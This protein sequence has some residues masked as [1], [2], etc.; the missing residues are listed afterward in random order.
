MSLE[1][2]ELIINSD[3]SIYHLHLLPEDI[4]DTILLVGDPNRVPMVSK[5]FD[6]IELKKE[7]REFFTHT[8]VLNGKRLTVISTGIGTDNVDIVMNEVDALV[9]IDLAKRTLKEQPSKLKFVRIGTSGG[10]NPDTPVDSFVLSSHGIGWDGLGSFYPYQEKGQA[11]SIKQS[12]KELIS[13]DLNLPVPYV[14]T[15][16][17]KLAQQFGNDFVQGITMTCTGFY[18]P[19]GRSLRIAAPMKEAMDRLADMRFGKLRNGNCRD[20]HACRIIRPSSSKL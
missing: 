13:D 2:S 1:A 15:G 4:A 5:C 14:T 11:L 20:L 7:K 9:N 19:Q 12:I 8:G 10:I 16:S 18:G 17:E 3:G 6:T